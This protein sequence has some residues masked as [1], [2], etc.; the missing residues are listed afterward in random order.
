MNKATFD[1]DLVEVGVTDKVPLEAFKAVIVPNDK[2]DLVKKMM[3][4]DNILVLGM[5]YMEGKYYY[6]EEG[7]ITI[8]EN[9]F[10][11]VNISR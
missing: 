7:F 3:S 1:T 9:D 4:N 5:N 6:F 2:V 10:K 11:Q 8:Q